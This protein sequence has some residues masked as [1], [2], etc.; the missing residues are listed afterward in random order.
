M[1]HQLFFRALNHFLLILQLH[2]LEL[3]R[4]QALPD[5]Q[6]GSLTPDDALCVLCA[7]LTRQPDVVHVHYHGFAGWGSSFEIDSAAI[8]LERRD[9][10]SHEV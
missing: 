5:S 1:Y 7:G 8:A 6:F 2:R 10:G 9:R 4:Q 3:Q